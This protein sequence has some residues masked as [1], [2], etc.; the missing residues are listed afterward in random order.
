[1]NVKMKNVCA[2]EKRSL[3]QKLLKILTA[4]FPHTLFSSLF[5]NWFFSKRID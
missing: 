3:L 4:L 1:M 2:L 5:T